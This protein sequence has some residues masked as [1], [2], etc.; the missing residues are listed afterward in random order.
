LTVTVSPSFPDW[1]ALRMMFPKR[2]EELII[3]Q[4][5]DDAFPSLMKQYLPD[6]FDAGLQHF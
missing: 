1:R 4:D 2:A 6:K 3:S 5:I